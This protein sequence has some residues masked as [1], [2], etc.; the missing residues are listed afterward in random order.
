MILV[1]GQ[2]VYESNDGEKRQDVRSFQFFSAL[3]NLIS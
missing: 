3:L 1:R 2:G